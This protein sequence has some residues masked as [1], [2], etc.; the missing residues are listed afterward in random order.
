MRGRIRG[1]LADA[2]G[3]LLVA[4]IPVALLYFGLGLG[5]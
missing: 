1:F 2:A 4:A 5:F 3:A